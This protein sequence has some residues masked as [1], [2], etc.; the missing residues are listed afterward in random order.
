MEK[1]KR[2]GDGESSEWPERK[3]RKQKKS[4]VIKIAKINGEEHV[5]HVGKLV[6]KRQTGKDCRNDS[7][8][9]KTTKMLK[10][11]IDFCITKTTIII[12]GATGL[13][14]I[15]EEIHTA[16]D[17]VQKEQK[18]DIEGNKAS[19]NQKRTSSEKLPRKYSSEKQ[20]KGITK[21][22]V[23]A[24][25]HRSDDFNI[26]EYFQDQSEQEH[27]ED[28]TLSSQSGEQEIEAKQQPL[29]ESSTTK[30]PPRLGIFWG[31]PIK[32][33]AFA[34]HQVEEQDLQQDT[35][36]TTYGIQ[37]E[38]QY[39]SDMSLSMGKPEQK[40]TNADMYGRQLKKKR[41]YHAEEQDAG[42]FVANEQRR[43]EEMEVF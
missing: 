26:N 19:S 22:I 37:R 17:R 11:Q 34:Q 18:D 24:T 12:V 2:H 1:F 5:N 16:E 15:K 7:S 3:K 29:E 9:R 30:K 8:T 41:I 23:G 32:Q 28:T 4:S 36:Q 40:L 35:E 14:P 13:R 6:N 39:Y 43:R 42:R 38:N 31:R 25:Q 21:I 20:P 27:Y 10:K 33:R